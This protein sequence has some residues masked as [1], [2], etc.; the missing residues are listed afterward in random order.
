MKLVDTHCHLDSAEFSEDLFHVIDTAKQAGIIKFIVPGIHPNHWKTLEQLDS[1]FPEIA[2]AP[3][4]HPLFIENLSLSHTVQLLEQ[5]IISTKAVA[6]GEIGLDFYHDQKNIAEQK[7]F[8]KAQLQLAISAKLPV[9]LH[10]RKAHD[11]IL[12][13]L[14][15]QHYGQRGKGGIVHAFCGSMEQAKQYRQLGFCFGVGG[16]ITYPR[17]TKIRKIMANLPL[18]ALVLETDAPD[19]P[20]QGYQGEANHPH[21]LVKIAGCLAELRQETTEIIA[22]YTTKNAKALFPYI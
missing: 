7:A 4:T 21:Q 17:A 2:I 13:L 14:R 5:V 16:V 6:I 11:T 12:S 9:L 18:Q 1:R 8:F 22:E 10:V 3:G 19:M 20:L 15:K